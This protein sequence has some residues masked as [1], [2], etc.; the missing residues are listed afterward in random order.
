M[1][2]YV[3]KC[4]NMLKHVFIC[5]YVWKCVILCLLDNQIMRGKYACWGHE[6]NRNG[7]GRVRSSMKLKHCHR[8]AWHRLCNC[9][10]C[11]VWLLSWMWRLLALGDLDH[12][13]RIFFGGWPQE[14]RCSFGLTSAV[15]NAMSYLASSNLLK[16]QVWGIHQPGLCVSVLKTSHGRCRAPSFIEGKFGLWADLKIIAG[17]GSSRRKRAA[18]DEWKKRCACSRGYSVSQICLNVQCKVEEYVL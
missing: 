6:R 17:I 4:E 10:T 14:S 16:R 7:S 12:W 11:A 8:H 13:T 15:R 9:V 3:D 18:K 1:W 5:V 2:K